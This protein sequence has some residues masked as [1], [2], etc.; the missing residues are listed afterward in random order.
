MPVSF[1]E[2]ADDFQHDGG[3]RDIYVRDIGIAQWNAVIRAVTSRYRWSYSEDGEACVVPDD[4][5]A[6]FSARMERS[7]LL[8]C[9]I[10]S[11]QAN[12]HFFD[13][14]E[15]EF[16]IQPSDVSAANFGELTAFMH[17]LA[18][19]AGQPAVIT[20]EGDSNAIMRIDPV[21]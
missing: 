14:T 21:A 2:V 4:A 8:T 20:H 13:P 11:M 9:R 18:S 12:C 5:A 7:A 3:L 17:L 10:G 19:V 1:Q 6:I 15:I 16:D